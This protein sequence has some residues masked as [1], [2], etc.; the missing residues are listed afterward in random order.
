VCRL[1]KLNQLTT[2]VERQETADG[3]LLDRINH[4]LQRLLG[5]VGF[6][7]VNETLIGDIGYLDAAILPRNGS[8]RWRRWEER[9]SKRRSTFAQTFARVLNQG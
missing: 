6:A 4:F 3:T 1:R 7:P 8:A 2:A 9:P 5:F